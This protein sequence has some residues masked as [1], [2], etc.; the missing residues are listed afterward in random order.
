MKMKTIAI[1]VV[2]LSLAAS[3]ALAAGF[4]EWMQAERMTVAKVD[5]VALAPGLSALEHASHPLSDLDRAR[6]PRAPVADNNHARVSR[7]RCWRC[8]LVGERRTSL[9]QCDAF[10]DLG[11]DPPRVA[12][13]EPTKQANRRLDRMIDRA[14]AVWQ[15]I[16]D[17][18]DP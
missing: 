13:S 8:R 14:V 7:E 12:R 10:G 6:K 9:E 17:M 3:A 2:S 11:L 15:S 1:S 5:H 16:E 4:T 18:L